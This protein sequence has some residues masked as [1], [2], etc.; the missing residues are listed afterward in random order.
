LEGQRGVGEVAVFFWLKALVRAF[1]LP[2]GFSLVLTLLGALLIWRRR[3][4]GWLVFVL[5]FGSL[6]LECTPIVADSL[7]RLAEGYPAFDPSKPTGAQAIVILGG[8][9]ERLRAPEYDG[10]F[11][12]P[13]LL[14]RLALGAYLARRLSLPVLVSGAPSEAISMP[15]TLSRN[16]GVSP[17][18][19]EGHSRDTYEN[20]QLSA[21]ILLPAGVKRIILVTTSTHEWR[22]AHEFMSAGLEVVPAPAGVL[23]IREVGIFRYVPEPAALTRSNAAIYELV[24]EPMRRLQAALRVRERFDKRV[25][26][27]TPLPKAG[28]EPATLPAQ[29]PALPMPQ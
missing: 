14:E 15:A 29:A 5:G 4:S 17:R 24:G 25:T 18:W 1:I 23:S 2:P 19:I 16:F 28:S 21:R 8:G 13:T 27:A 20:A 9:G 11:A 6:W 10:P 12:E 7:S 3:R 26:E 22:A